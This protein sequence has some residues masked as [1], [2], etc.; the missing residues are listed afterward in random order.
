MWT[1]S[2][3]R[4]SVVMAAASGRLSSNEKSVPQAMASKIAMPKMPRA[5]DALYSLGN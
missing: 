1:A 5:T 4:T 3:P 2:A